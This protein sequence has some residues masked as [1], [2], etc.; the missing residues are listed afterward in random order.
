M[1]KFDD[2]SYKIY[3]SSEIFF[4]HL[5]NNIKIFNIYFDGILGEFLNFSTEIYYS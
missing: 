3:L 2:D 4:S 1:K 5:N